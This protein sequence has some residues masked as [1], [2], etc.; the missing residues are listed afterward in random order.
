MQQGRLPLVQAV[1]HPAHGASSAALAGGKLPES[2]RS[3]ELLLT[4][5]TEQL[6]DKTADR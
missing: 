2:L 3:A 6:G 4:R 1:T 5:G